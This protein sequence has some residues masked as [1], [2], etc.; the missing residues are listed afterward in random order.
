MRGKVRLYLLMIFVGIL[1]LASVLLA[2][3]VAT[4]NGC[5]IDEGGI[6]PCQVLGY[7]AGPLLHTMTTLGWLMLV[8]NLFLA[9]GVLGLLGELLRA[10]GLRA[11]QAFTRW[12]SSQ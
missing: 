9:A 5:R 11:W 2:G 6:H 1:P 12:R 3:Q 10:A 7:E 4:W 8:T